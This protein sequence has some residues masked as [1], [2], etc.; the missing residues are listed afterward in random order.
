[1]HSIP[2]ESSFRNEFVKKRKGCKK[3]RKGSVSF[4]KLC[5]FLMGVKGHLRK[6]ETIVRNQVVNKGFTVFDSI[7]VLHVGYLSSS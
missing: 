1:M 4:K 6:A 5:H 7:L 2:A 3:K